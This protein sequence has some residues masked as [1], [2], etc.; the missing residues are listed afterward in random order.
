MSMAILSR[1]VQLAVMGALAVALL[2]AAVTA[3]SRLVPARPAIY[4]ILWALVLVPAAMMAIGAMAARA[5]YFSCK[6]PNESVAVSIAVALFAAAAGIGLWWF[7]DMASGT[8][9]A[10]QEYLRTLEPGGY[11][12]LGFLLVVY[13]V[14]GAIGGIVDY[15]VSWGRQCETGPGRGNP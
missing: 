13:A 6:G 12:D 9:G 8:T 14:A 11:Q 10:I 4:F 5:A 7:V 15:Y 3:I 1:L 2:S